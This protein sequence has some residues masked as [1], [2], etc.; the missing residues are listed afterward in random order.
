M[1][2]ARREL[3]GRSRLGGLRPRGR[4]DGER[5]A[6]W[7]PGPVDAGDVAGGAVP[8]FDGGVVAVRSRD[9]EQ[10]HEDEGDRSRAADRD[11]PAPEAPC[12]GTPRHGARA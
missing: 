10:G 5:F 4:E 12:D 1:G 6:F 9:V 2:L 8:L 11:Q 3:D 7:N